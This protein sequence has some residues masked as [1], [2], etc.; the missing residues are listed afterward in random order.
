M[1]PQWPD[2]IVSEIA[3]HALMGETFGPA[4]AFWH[5]C[6]LTAWFI[7][8]GPYSRTDIEGVPGYYQRQLGALEQLGTPIDFRLFAE[9]KKAEARLG[10]AVPWERSTS[11]TAVGSGISIE[12]RVGMGSRRSGFENL[13]DVITRYRRE[14]AR[15]HLT[16]YLRARWE[17]DL[18]E[19][20]RLYAQTIA[21]KGKP[22]APK[23]FARQ[24]AVATNR[25]FGGDI[26]GFCAAIGEKS[27]FRPRLAS[28]MP[29]DRRGFATKVLAAL[30]KYRTTSSGVTEPTQSPTQ[31]NDDLERLAEESLRVV[32]L[33]EALG[34]SPTQKEFGRFEYWAPSLDPKAD[35]AWEIYVRLIEAELDA[36]AET[37]GKR[38]PARQP[39]VMPR[40]IDSDHPSAVDPQAQG[41]TPR[42]ESWFARLL[43]YWRSR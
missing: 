22:P 24:A 35:R 37:A 9:L 4:L 7:S 8:E 1:L 23:Q 5:G 14:W 25:W 40:T 21:D 20:A 39:P 12:M 34:R 13:R 30:Q 31:R 33:R 19:P 11:S 36:P 43:N 15:Q 18:R 26:S 3:P 32:Q 42:K 6:A 27:V 2:R 38:D 28:L 10:P 41:A 29:A 17:W 16:A